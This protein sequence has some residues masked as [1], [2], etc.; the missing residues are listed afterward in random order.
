MSLHHDVPWETIEVVFLDAGGTVVTFDFEWVTRELAALGVT[1]TVADLERAEAAARPAVSREALERLEGGRPFGFQD[2][3]S[4]WFRNLPAKAALPADL[5]PLV[6][7][8]APTLRP[9]GESFRLWSVVMP[10]V[11]EALAELRSMGLRIAVVSNSDGSAERSLRDT[12]LLALIDHVVD[13]AIVGVE[14]PDPAIFSHALDA[15]RCRPE[16]VVHVGDMFF[17]D[18][19]G[20]RRAGIHA[21]L[22]DPYGDW[23]AVDCLRLGSVADL[24]RAFRSGRKR[25]SGAVPDPLSIGLIGDRSPEVKAHRAIPAALELVADKLG[26]DLRYEWIATDSIASADRVAGYDG[27]WCVPGSPYRSMDGALLAIRHARERGIPFLGTCGGFQHAVIEYAR[28]VLGWLDAEHGESAPGAGRAVISLLACPLVD[29]A[30]P[31]RLIAGSR[32]AA[33]Y[34]VERAIED[35]HC[36]FGLNPE[37]RAALAGGPLAVSAVDD[38]G[39]VRALELANHPFFVAMLCQPERIALRGSIPPLVS[40][41]VTACVEAATARSLAT[42]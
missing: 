4:I 40:A 34:G 20:A 22:L 23:G 31:I 36:S 15:M 2:F 41:F 33:A 26:L 5:A 14:K 25:R 8:L 11:R 27:M 16:S 29:V 39:A 9:P 12:G 13:S 38:D 24:P 28:N 3:L 35:Y 42:A 19:V 37:F 7:A 6:A 30:G 18:V 21:V 10:G 32:A 17:A 1:C